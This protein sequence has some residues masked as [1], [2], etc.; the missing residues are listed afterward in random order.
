ME[1]RFDFDDQLPDLPIAFDFDEVAGV[2]ER[3]LFDVNSPQDP[4][5]VLNIKKMQDLKYR[6]SH[7]CVTTYEMMIGKAD[8]APERTIG[9]LEFTPEGVL[10]RLYT[11]DDRLPWLSRA[12]DMNEM[13]RLFS[14]LPGFEGQVKL[15]E[16]FPV[17]YKPGL[18]C[19][20]RYTV[21]TPAG[22]EMFYGKSFSGNAERLMKAITDLHKSSQDNPDM[23]LISAPVAVW[24][25][26][27]M[28]LQTAV[29]NGIEF[30]Q[31]AYDQKYDRSEEHTSELQSRL[32]LVC[33]L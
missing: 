33:R 3:K 2:F 7:R 8:S 20:I 16:I 6:P 4:A 1:Y 15:L 21:E 19:V 14:E 11:A 17:R 29:P 5:T 22:K 10:P 25:E 9:V 24:P 30:T 26:M 28:I 13:Q 12:S 27:E 23:P 32:H 31:F 18:H